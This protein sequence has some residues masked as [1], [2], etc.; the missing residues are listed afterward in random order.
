MA[1]LAMRTLAADPGTATLLLVSKPPDAEVAK[2]VLAEAGGKPTAAALIGLDPAETG[3]VVGGSACLAPTLEQGAVAAA[4]LAGATVPPLADGLAERVASACRNLP[5][6]RR[7]VRGYFSGGTL[8]YETQVILTGLVGPVY[9]NEP[10]DGDRVPAPPGSHVC[11]DLGAE[12]YTRGRPHPMI[13][14]AV[15]RELLLDQAADA[16]AD[17]VAV[18]MLDVVLGFGSHPDPAGVLA[19][20]CAELMA[21]GGPQVVAYVLGASADPQDFQAQ[22]R[23]LSDAGCIVPETSARGA[24]AAAALALRRPE[25]A[26]AGL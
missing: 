11:L 5:A 24:Y 23:T 13:D 20:V 2:A 1:R 26:E 10:L 8:C 21:G 18:I 7:L 22:R 25:L 16:E 4:G 14:P 9:S 12:E 19:P 3:L 15:R 17:S 6:S